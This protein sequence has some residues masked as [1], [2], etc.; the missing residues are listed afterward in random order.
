MLQ[1]FEFC[2]FRDSVETVKMSSLPGG[3][4]RADTLLSLAQ[5]RSSFTCSHAHVMMN[6][7]FLHLF[8]SGKVQV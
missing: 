1:L 7:F 2:P 4:I 6:S 8:I 5:M 3:S